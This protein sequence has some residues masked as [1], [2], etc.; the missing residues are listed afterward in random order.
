MATFIRGTQPVNTWKH[1]GGSPIIRIVTS[2]ELHKALDA[3]NIIRC[4]MMFINCINPEDLTPEQWLQIVDPRNDETPQCILITSDPPE[5]FCLR[6]THG[7]PDLAVMMLREMKKRC[8]PY[9]L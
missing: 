4:D 2:R 1:G 3:K 6:A 8:N 5:K 7:D 9:A